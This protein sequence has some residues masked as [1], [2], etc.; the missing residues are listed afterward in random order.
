MT[1]SYT[2]LADLI[3]AGGLRRDSWAP[4][5]GSSVQWGESTSRET[6]EV[7]LERAPL[8]WEPI[9]EACHRK[10]GAIEIQQVLAETGEDLIVLDGV[11]RSAY[12]LI[13][14]ARGSLQL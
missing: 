1:Q 5:Y 4:E 9:G 8:V 2:N 14:G 7:N 10:P 11:Q 6:V 3:R 13:I 12:P